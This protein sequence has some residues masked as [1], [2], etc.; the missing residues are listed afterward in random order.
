MRPLPRARPKRSWS[1]PPRRSASTSTTREPAA[2]S[3][4]AR[5]AAATSWWSLARAARDEDAAHRRAHRQELHARA[6]G[7]VRLGLRRSRVVERDRPRRRSPRAPLRGTIA[8]TGRREKR[9]TSW[10]VRTLSVRSS[11]PNAPA[12]PKMRPRTSPTMPYFTGWG[13]L[14]VRR[15]HA[16]RRS[17]ATVGCDVAL[18]TRS[19]PYCCWSAVYVGVDRRE[20]RGAGRRAS[21]TIAAGLCRPRR[22]RRRASSTRVGLGRQLRSGACVTCVFTALSWF[23][24]DAVCCLVERGLLRL[25]PTRRRPWRTRRRPGPTAPS[26]AIP[27]VILMTFV[28]RT[29]LTLTCLMAFGS[30]CIVGEDVVLEVARP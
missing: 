13:W 7:A 21:A 18:S 22:P 14:A 5:L 6:R 17:G 25:R 30:R 23:R 29:L 2:A 26:C 8:S 4:T 15:Q 9:S 12:M 20:L 27:I 28:L 10:R 19:W 24:V 3:V 11:K 16:R 1:W